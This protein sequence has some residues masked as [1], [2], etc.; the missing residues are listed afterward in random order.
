MLDIL[1]IQGIGGP[2]ISYVIT[3]VVLV[4]V[5]SLPVTKLANSIA[6]EVW[7][8]VREQHRT[9][10]FLKGINDE[11][12]PFASNSQTLVCTWLKNSENVIVML[13]KKHK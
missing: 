13:V 2:N 8:R 3:M 7:K 9:G 6:L 11:R 10:L 4:I 1:C 5:S 12:E